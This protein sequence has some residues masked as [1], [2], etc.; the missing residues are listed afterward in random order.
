MLH[1]RKVLCHSYFLAKPVSLNVQLRNAEPRCSDSAR[2]TPLKSH[3]VN[4][5][6]SVRSRLRSS[7][8]K[9]RPDEFAVRPIHYAVGV[10]LA[11]AYSLTA[12]NASVADLR[13]RASMLITGT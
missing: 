9:S 3:S 10:K 6:R 13:S 5:T 4:T 7:S 8:R 1:W 2:L 11:S 12:I